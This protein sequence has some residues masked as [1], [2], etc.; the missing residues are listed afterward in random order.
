MLKPSKKGSYHL[1]LLSFLPKLIHK[2]LIREK[3]QLTN[4]PFSK[5]I[6][7]ELWMGRAGSYMPISLQFLLKF[8]PFNVSRFLTN[9]VVIK[10]NLS[11][12]LLQATL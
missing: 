1:F 2:L 10:F 7:Y 4:P 12:F 3:Y 6:S 11:T 9:Y 5:Q 8:N